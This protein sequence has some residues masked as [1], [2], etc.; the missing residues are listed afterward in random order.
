MKPMHAAISAENDDWKRAELRMKSVASEY[1]I[2]RANAIARTGEIVACDASGCRTGVW[3]FTAGLLVLMWGVNKIVPTLEDALNPVRDYAYQLENIRAMKVYGT[4]SM[5]GKCVILAH[6]KGSRSCHPD[7]CTGSTGILD[8]D[9]NGLLPKRPV[10]PRGFAG[11]V[12]T[13]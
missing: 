8:A 7:P 10:A 5:I 1:F 4:P 6:E 3:P 2:S 11:T 9:V 13:G 12:F